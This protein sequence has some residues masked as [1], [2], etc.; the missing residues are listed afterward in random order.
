M[1]IAVPNAGA[2]RCQ[3]IA[4]LSGWRCTRTSASAPGSS[5]RTRQHTRARAEA[6]AEP[7]RRAA[8][9]AFC[10]R[11]R[12]RSDG[13]SVAAR[14][15]ASRSDRSAA[16]PAARA[17]APPL[18][19][20][21]SGRRTRPSGSSAGDLGTWFRARCGSA[22][23]PGESD[24]DQQRAEAAKAIEKKTNTSVW[25]L[26]LRGR[27]PVDFVRRDGQARVVR[28]GRGR[29]RAARGSRGSTHQSARQETPAIV[30][31]TTTIAPSNMRSVTSSSA[32]I[33]ESATNAS[34]ARVKRL[35]T[36][37]RCSLSPQRNRMR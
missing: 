31:V 10:S 33:M 8:A 26:W 22:A 37:T 24:V 27:C 5:P 20:S 1:P 2:S 13:P 12:L 25:A 15:R 34:P 28:E 16:G 19:L 18:R 14:G 32:P 30:T 4:A 29:P 9:S 36:I 17:A 21:H 35:A 7:A 11:S 6:T 23:D 3:P